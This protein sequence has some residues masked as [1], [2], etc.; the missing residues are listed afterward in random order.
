MKKGETR[1]DSVG[2]FGKSEYFLYKG[3]RERQRSQ[4][5]SAFR[6]IQGR[7]G[8]PARKLSRVQRKGSFKK[9]TMSE[10][11]GLHRAPAR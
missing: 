11:P 6:Q 7:G 9:L 3:V 1:A 10:I 4:N 5:K 2:G 8:E